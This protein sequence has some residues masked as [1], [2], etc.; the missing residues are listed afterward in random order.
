MSAAPPAPAPSPGV[1]QTAFP[2]ELRILKTPEEMAA[3]E[4]LARAVWPGDDLDVAPAHLLLAVAHNG[5]L[6]AG[7]FAGDRLAGFVFGFPGLTAPLTASSPQASRRTGS[8]AAPPEL[9]PARAGA[10]GAGPAGRSTHALPTPAG[11]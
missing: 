8:P 9:S 1:R 5:G 10:S 6:V 7:A 2:C 3:V 4:E 11:P